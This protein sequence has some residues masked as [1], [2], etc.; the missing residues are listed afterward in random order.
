MGETPEE[1]LASMEKAK[2]EG[3]DIAELKLHSMHSINDVEKVIKHRLL[4]LII[5]FR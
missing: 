4:P 5:S 2:E 1:M 3:A